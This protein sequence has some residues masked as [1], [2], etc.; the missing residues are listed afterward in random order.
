M[1]LRIKIL[2]KKEKESKKLKEIAVI[3]RKFSLRTQTYFRL[4]LLSFWRREAT[5]RNTSVFA[6]QLKLC[7]LFVELLECGFH[8]YYIWLVNI[9]T[10]LAVFKEMILV[11]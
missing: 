7:S 9:G 6:G 5:A 10:T 2:E 11:T 1:K 8:R 3:L 4:L